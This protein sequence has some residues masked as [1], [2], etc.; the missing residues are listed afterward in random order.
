[1]TNRR[2][3]KGQYVKTIS[4]TLRAKDVK[5]LDK[6]AKQFKNRSE[7]L[8]VLIEDAAQKGKEA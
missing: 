1:M 3:E 8:R 7:V 5:W 6:M 4:V 2:L